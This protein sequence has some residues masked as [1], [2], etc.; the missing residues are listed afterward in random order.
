MFQIYINGV[1]GINMSW[2]G[3]FSTI[4]KLPGT[5]DSHFLSDIDLSH[6]V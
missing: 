5:F 3:F 1:V 6:F 4:N 2:V